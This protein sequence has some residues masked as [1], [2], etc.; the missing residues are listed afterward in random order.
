MVQSVRYSGN[1]HAAPGDVSFAYS[2][3][4]IL[5]GNTY[6]KYCDFTV[7]G[8]ANCSTGTTY[9]ALTRMV[10]S[11]IYKVYDPCSS[12]ISEDLWYD[13]GLN[14]G[15]I[16]LVYPN[17]LNSCAAIVDSVYM[18]TMLNGQSRR[19][20]RLHGNNSLGNFVY[21]WVEGIGD[22]DRG[23]FANVDFEGGHDMFVCHQE[24]DT[25]VWANNNLSPYCHYQTVTSI[26]NIKE[27]N[28]EISPNPTNS[29]LNIIDKNN[30]FKN[31]TIQI[32]NYLGQV[33]FSTPFASQI[34]LSDFSAGIYFLTIQ[35][36]YNSKTIKIIKQ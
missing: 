13:W 14:V 8:T 20:I 17:N 12:S 11:K 31:S 27:N 32:K 3:D 5:C 29:I 21:R 30:Q 25:L 34:N 10:G 19:Y 15:D 7:G 36:R 33:I 23:F 6:S 9:G 18:K 4:T 28:L 22:I 24:N 26:N 35:N 16:M 2:G 1:V